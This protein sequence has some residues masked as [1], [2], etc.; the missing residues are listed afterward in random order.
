MARIRTIKPEFFTS[1][2]IVALS[3]LGRLLFIALWCEADREG[4]LAWKPKTFKMRYLPADDCD[5]E[6]LCNELLT[7]GVLKTYG[8]GLA[9][10]PSFL[11]HQ[12]VNPR[13]TQS[14]LPEPTTKARV[15]TRQA[16]VATGE[17]LDVHVQGGREGKGREGNVTRVDDAFVEFWDAWPKSERKQDKAKCADKFKAQELCEL[18]PLI[19]A[20]IETK[21]RTEKWRGGFIEAPEVYINNRRWEDGVTPGGA[22]LADSVFAGA[23]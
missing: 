7:Q 4:R 2:D 20:D 10:I 16:R 15:G 9:Y 5:I 22:D 18:L 1:E 14:T 11:S 13:E 8:D 6:A 17:N 23:V 12:H 21:K 19:L 3:P